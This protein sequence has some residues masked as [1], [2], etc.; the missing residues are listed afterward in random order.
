MNFPSITRIQK[1]LRVEPETARAIRAHMEA[2]KGYAPSF[3]I[4]LPPAVLE[5]ARSCYH[6]PSRGAVHRAALAWII[7]EGRTIS[8]EVFQPQEEWSSFQ[9]GPVWEAVETGDPYVP[10]LIH[11]HRRYSIGCW[12]DLPEAN[13]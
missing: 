4:T 12:G 2:S 13:R 11:R 10:T 7:T 9:D 3:P 8:W 5:W 1:L 6:R